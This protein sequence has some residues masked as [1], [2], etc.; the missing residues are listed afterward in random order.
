MRSSRR[1][2][3]FLFASTSPTAEGGT[4]CNPAF[5]PIRLY[6]AALLSGRRPKTWSRDYC[7]RD[8]VPAGTARGEDGGLNAHETCELRRDHPSS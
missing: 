6:T 3:R 8:L 1:G 4:V 2:A 7:E 5:L